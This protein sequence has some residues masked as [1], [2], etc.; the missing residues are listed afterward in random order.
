MAG[1]EARMRLIAAAAKEWGAP[2]QSCSVADGYVVFTSRRKSFGELAE[3]AAALPKPENVQLKRRNE[4][5]YIGKP[6][7]RL[8]TPS[9]V[10]GSA[11]FGIDVRLPDMLYAALAQPPEL[12]ASVK[13]FK[14]DAAQGMPGVRQVLQTSSGVAVIA[15]SWWQ[16][17]QA[18]DALQI[19]WAPGTNAKLTNAAI[20]AGLKSAASGKGKQVRKDGDADSCAEV[21][22][23]RRADLRAADARAR[24]AG[25]AELHGRVSRRRLPRL[26]ADAGS[27]ARAGARRRRLRDCR[28]RKCS[29]TRRS[30]AAASAGGSRSTSFRRRSNA[31]RPLNKPVKVLWTREDDMT[32]DKYRPPARNTLS[33]AF[34]PAGKLSAVKMHLVAPSIT[35]RWVPGGRRQGRGRS[36]RGRSRSQLPVRRAERVHRLPAARDRHRRRL[37]ALGEPRAQLLRRREL[38]GRAGVRSAARSVRVPPRHARQAAALA[39]GAGHGCEEGA[40]GDAR[41]AVVIR[42][43][44]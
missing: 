20:S 3:A 25:A 16:A 31:R 8:D 14:A 35:S 13:S 27:A 33:G 9:K 5:K 41:R 10:D 21:R 17:H 6:Q 29:C 19:E 39:D 38:H 26:R 32:H 15:D 11:Q 18:R 42:A 30:S 12:G 22:P 44:R 2:P 40:A 1:A 34:D 28:P 4:F 24:D 36:V 43:S 23:A 7:Q 37:L